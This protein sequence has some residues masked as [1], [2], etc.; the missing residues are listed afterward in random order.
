MKLNYTKF[1]DPKEKNKKN[2][3]SSW[4]GP[5]THNKLYNKVGQIYER[6][7]DGIILE[8][9]FERQTLLVSLNWELDILCQTYNLKKLDSVP[10]HVNLPPLI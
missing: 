7:F 2:G 8:L 1:L 5:Y 3:P 6:Y 4:E 10:S 9:T